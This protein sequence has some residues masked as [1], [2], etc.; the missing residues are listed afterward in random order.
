MIRNCRVK[1]LCV[2][3]LALTFILGTM[4]AARTPKPAAAVKRTVKVTMA[5]GTFE[6]KMTPLAADAT[7]TEAG[8]GSYSIEKVWHG[9]I[10]GTSKAQMLATQFEDEGQLYIALEKVT[11]TIGGRKGTFVFEHRGYMKKGVPN[12]S[13]KVVP[14]SGT[15][16]LAGIVGKLDIK[17]EGG[18]H[19]YEFEY[20][21]PAKP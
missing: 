1:R 14:G 2:T 17:I 10:D 6:V 4:I 21:L 13:V 18:K 16:E 8:L 3:A 15:G 12:L 11:A 19:F 7:A 20:S 5:K 9:D